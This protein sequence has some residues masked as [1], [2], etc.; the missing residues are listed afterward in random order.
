VVIHLYGFRRSTVPALKLANGERAQTTRA[1]ARKLDSAVP[2]PRLVGDGPGW[3]PAE[4][5]ADE[6]FQN[7]PRRLLRRLA[8]RSTQMRRDIAH[9]SPLPFP[10]AQARITGPVASLLA[11]AAG[12]SEDHIEADMRAFP[13]TMDEVDTLLTGGVA[14]S[15][16]P[17]ALALQLIVTT[18]TLLRFTELRPILEGRPSTKLAEAL[19]VPLPGDVVASL[20]PEWVAAAGV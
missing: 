2:E 14:R 15:D 4:Q 7:I 5:W 16:P 3:A 8:A 1:I 6:V 9:M 12:A 20:P 10:D 19:D 18:K 17:D 13:E 11:R